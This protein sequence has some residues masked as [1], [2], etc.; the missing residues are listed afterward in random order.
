MLMEGQV[1]FFSP[2]N[3]AGV[4]QEIGVTIVLNGD[5]NSSVKIKQYNKI[6]K[7]T[8]TSGEVQ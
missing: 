3:A 7:Q 2:Q 5:Q 6:K 1:K 8:L 4:S